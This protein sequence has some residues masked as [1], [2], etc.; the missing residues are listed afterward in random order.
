MAS[1]ARRWWRRCRRIGGY[2]VLVA[3]IVLALLVAIANQFLPAVEKHPEEVARWLSERVGQP[4]RFSGIDARWTRQGPRFALDGLVVGEGDRQLAI[5]RADLQVSV[6]SGLFPGM[7]LTE[8]SVDGL[9]LTLHQDADG[10]WRMSGLPQ[11]AQVGVDPFD[12]LS[13]FG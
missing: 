11:P 2:G 9:S 6:Y 5:G 7:P 10:R 12:V 1:A 3:L 8:L 4:V 13:G